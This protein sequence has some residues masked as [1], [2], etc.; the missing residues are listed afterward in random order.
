M[1]TVFVSNWHFLYHF[2]NCFSEYVGNV[3]GL[4]QLGDFNFIFKNKIQELA[5]WC[6]S[7]KDKREIKS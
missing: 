5:K 4:I 2:H 3:D 6:G 7:L 1:L